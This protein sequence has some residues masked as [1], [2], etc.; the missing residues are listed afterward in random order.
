VAAARHGLPYNPE[1]NSMEFTRT[2][3]RNIV[4]ARRKADWGLNGAT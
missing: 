1:T 4:V 2:L 3:L